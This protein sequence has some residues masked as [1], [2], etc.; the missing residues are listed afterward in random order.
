MKLNKPGRFSMLMLGNSR[1]RI[2][3]VGNDVT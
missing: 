1:M 2:R 3:E